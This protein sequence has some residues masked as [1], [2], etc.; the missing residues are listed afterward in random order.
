MVYRKGELNTAGIDRGW[1]HQVAL[2]ASRTHGAEYVTA[3][4]FC[5]QLSL[6]P[7][8]HAFLRDDDYYTVW[9]FA[10]AAHAEA[11]RA[12][13]GGE[14]MDPKDRPRWPNKAPRRR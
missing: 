8:S 4:L 6:C 1:P 9:C 5:A 10:E 14:I 3:R 12:R 11:F 2:L 7:R 13:F